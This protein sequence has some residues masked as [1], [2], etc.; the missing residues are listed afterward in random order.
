MPEIPAKSAPARLRPGPHLFP[1]R[2]KVEKDIPGPGT[3][4]T[5]PRPPAGAVRRHKLL[6]HMKAEGQPMTSAE[7]SALY[8]SWGWRLYRSAVR[9][10][11]QKLAKD[12]LLEQDDTDPECRVY[13]LLS[14]APAGG[15][16]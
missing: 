1:P 11:L 4:S 5:P 2:K 13:R 12:G 9:S 3:A 16:S 15:T 8:Y 7:A 14:S 10:D 6:Q